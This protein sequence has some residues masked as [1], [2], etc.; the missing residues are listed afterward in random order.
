MLVDGR[1]EWSAE[2]ERAHQ[3]RLDLSILAPRPIGAMSELDQHRLEVGEIVAAERN[4]AVSS[5]DR[6]ALERQAPRQ[7]AMR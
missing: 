5:F 1:P 4:R 6:V 7:G 2:D 3:I